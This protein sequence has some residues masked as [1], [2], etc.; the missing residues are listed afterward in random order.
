MLAVAGARAGAG[1]VSTIAWG[2]ED[3]EDFGYSVC[4]AVCSDQ[5]G[6]QRLLVADYDNHCLRSVDLQ[7]GTARR[8]T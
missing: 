5:S 2:S 8:I 1:V 4:A 3:G 7:T 6:K